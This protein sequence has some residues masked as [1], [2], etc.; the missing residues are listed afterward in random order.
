MCGENFWERIGIG[1]EPF[2]FI[3]ALI[4]C[5]I[6]FIVSVIGRIVLFIKKKK[7]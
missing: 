2:F 5:L 1:D 7:K 6:A 4:V 3:L